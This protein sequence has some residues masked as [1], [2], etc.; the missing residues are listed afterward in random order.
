MTNTCLALLLV[1]ATASANNVVAT[2]AEPERAAPHILDARIGFLLGGA[3][4][5]DASELSVGVSSSLGYRVG[6]VSLRGLFDYYRIG[7]GGDGPTARHGRA[8]RLGGALRYSFANNGPDSDFGLDFWGEAGGGWEHATWL[9][10]G[11]IDR[12]SVETAIG[13]DVFGR[14][15]QGESERR[16]MGYFIA[17]RTLIGEAPQVPGAMATCQGPCTMA[18]T[19]T[20]TDISM[21]F[22]LGVHW[23]KGH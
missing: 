2:S 12:P 8:T 16:Q 23:G 10:G 21:F 11:V 7:D 20:R 9:G 15:D 17:F 6:D 4:E 1:T 3:D 22:E 5:G 13:F 18:T 19:P 14:R